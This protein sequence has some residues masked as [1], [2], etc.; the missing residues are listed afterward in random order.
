MYTKLIRCKENLSSAS[1]KKLLESSSEFRIEDSVDDW[2]KKTVDVAE[3][4][5]DGEDNRVDVTDGHVIDTVSNTDCVQYI[6]CKK[7]KPAHEKHP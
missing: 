7:R 5:G 2:I 4:D 1:A 3:P 6:D